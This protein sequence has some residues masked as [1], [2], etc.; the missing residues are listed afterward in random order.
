MFTLRGTPISK[1]IV[2]GRIFIKKINKKQLRRS[3]YHSRGI[4][5]ETAEYFKSLE[6]LKKELDD[7][8]WAKREISDQT[9][10]QILDLCAALI[11]D[12][13]FAKRI[14]AYLAE[15]NCPAQTAILKKL[16]LLKLEFNK[17]ENEYFRSRFDDF[18]ALGNRLIDILNGDSTFMEFNHPAI[19]IAEEISPAE[20]M[21]FS[22]D[23]LLAVLSIKGG[24]TS[25]AAILAEAQGI[26]AVFGVKDLFSLQSGQRVIVDAYKGEIIVDPDEETRALYQSIKNRRKAYEEILIK[27]ITQKSK[28]ADGEALNIFAN[29]GKQEDISEAK[30]AH[31]DGIG[32]LRTE[33]FTLSDNQPLEEELLFKYYSKLLS[34]TDN[35]PVTIRTLDLGGDKFLES[36]GDNPLYEANPFLGYRSTRMFID[37]PRDLRIQLA[38]LLRAS[39]QNPNIKIMF[40]FV[41]TVDDF[42]V[43]RALY[44]EVVF[45]LKDS[46]PHLPSI[47]VGMMV[48]VPSVA[49]CLED[50]LPYV[51]FVSIGTNDL[52]QYTLAVDR[53]NPL[54]SKY[55]QNAHPSVLKLIKMTID[56]ASNANIPVSLCGEMAKEPCFT[57]LLLGMGLRTLS[58]NPSFLPLVKFIAVHSRI[59]ECKILSEKVL[60]MTK[61]QEIIAYLDNE[62]S[63]FLYK[64]DA[65]F[66]YENMEE[67]I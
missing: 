49:L 3:Y 66:D 17:L 46:L 6:K 16:S 36:T 23:H 11:R 12:D 7:L 39:A 65:A 27:A 60:T 26:P 4:E 13:F 50:F 63:F 14:P 42:L 21:R 31:V 64:H 33:V 34:L 25:H 30:K 62:L 5:I 61:S 41:S 52:T 8:K 56:K 47:P 38:G 22:A 29:I 28:T 2:E 35:I 24:I 48:E 44:D 1:G 55:Y 40:P 57:R 32:L 43:L 37:D 20:I 18:N 10:R 51:D 9:G 15:N 59:E 19:F 45:S 67:T 54:V 58:L 53:N